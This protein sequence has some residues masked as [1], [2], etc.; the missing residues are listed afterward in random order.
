M[1]DND[2]PYFDQ[3]GIGELEFSDNILCVERAGLRNNVTVT[4][5]TLTG[6]TT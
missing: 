1:Y 5:V 3:K 2:I 4:L 6:L